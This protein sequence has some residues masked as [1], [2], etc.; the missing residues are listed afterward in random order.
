VLN[1]THPKACIDVMLGAI[2][3]TS[4]AR[5]LENYILD[6]RTLDVSLHFTMYKY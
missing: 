5:D 2:A 4:G 6:L 3:L 1:I